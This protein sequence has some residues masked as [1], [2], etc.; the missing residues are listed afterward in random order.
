MHLPTPVIYYTQYVVSVA[1]L[2]N[3]GGPGKD[4]RPV[5]AIKLMIEE[6]NNCYKKEHRL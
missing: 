3:A 2:V 5:S 4:T 6:H 1:F